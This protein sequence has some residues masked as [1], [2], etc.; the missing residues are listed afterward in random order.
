MTW[1]TEKHIP[2]IYHEDSGFIEGLA[3]ES[4][5]DTVAGKV[6]RR[7]VGTMKLYDINRELHAPA[8][9]DLNEA[10]VLI[11]DSNEELEDYLRENVSN[12]SKEDF[13]VFVSL[14]REGM[15]EGIAKY[16]GFDQTN[17][18]L[19][20]QW[21]LFQYL[22]T[23]PVKELDDV[24]E[25]VT[26]HE[27]K[28]LRAFL[29]MEQGGREMSSSILQIDKNYDQEE[30]KQI[31]DTYGRLVDLSN[32]TADYI[33]EKFSG[34][35]IDSARVQQ[36]A[37]RGLLRGMALLKQ[38]AQGDYTSEQVSQKLGMIGGELEIVKGV[39][40]ELI[41]SGEIRNIQDLELYSARIL[42]G[43][44]ILSQQDIIQR[45]SELIDTEHGATEKSEDLKSE[46]EASLLKKDAKVHLSR[47][48]DV[49]ESF[50]VTYMIEDGA[51]HVGGLNVSPAARELK[52][53]P[54]IIDSILDDADRKKH[55]LVVE[56][57]PEKARIYAR[58][59]SFEKVGEEE[60]SGS[61]Y[62]ILRR[63][64][65]SASH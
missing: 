17:L 65:Q 33:S 32:S 28:G 20:E 50:C 55:D 60:F 59:Y 52:L 39:Y 19:K 6:L 24:A 64:P 3:E 35:K 23:V 53:G 15:R 8:S 18:S 4:K 61:Q 2:Y 62:Y 43:D 44:Y 26:N 1:D 45:M 7:D 13:E 56:A 21:Y 14:I 16:L 40:R 34:K 41:E 31:F 27:I 48:D 49:V 30:A 58:I 12:F 5:K 38:M 46:L 63:K 47:I 11:R 36:I 57:T 10:M 29:S 9:Y 42:S 22:K 51:M 37:Q 25:L 54:Q